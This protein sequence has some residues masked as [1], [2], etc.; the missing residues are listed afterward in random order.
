MYFI[1]GKCFDLL[2]NRHRCLNALTI[3]LK[4]DPAC[5]EI[6]EYISSRGLLSQRDGKQLLKS[7]VRIEDD[8][9]RSWLQP[10]YRSLPPS[11]F[12]PLLLLIPTPLSSLSLSIS[13]LFDNAAVPDS[14]TNL[15]NDLFEPVSSFE[16]S[17]HQDHEHDL[18]QPSS[19]PV[20][21]MALVQQAEFMYSHQHHEEA[22][23]LARQAYSIDPYD[24][25]GNLI[26]IA[27]M[28]DLGLKNELFYLG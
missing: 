7:V 17:L 5:I 22:Y 2:E 12:S 28:V 8:P 16:S 11:L 3:G 24:S 20:S 4:I 19:V 14:P 10:Y 6:A 26:Y 27:T 25:R 23:R 13:F 9:E 18:D 21:A 15:L 1:A